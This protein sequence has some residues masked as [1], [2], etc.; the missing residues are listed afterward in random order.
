MRVFLYLAFVCLLFV[1]VGCDGTKENIHWIPAPPCEECP[2]DCEDEPEGEHPVDP[3]SPRC[4]GK[5]LVC[6]KPGTPAEHELC[7]P[8]GALEAHLRHGDYLGE[9][10]D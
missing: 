3:E 5:V 10:R 2:D 4:E 6:H 7:V 9:C 8:D 1:G